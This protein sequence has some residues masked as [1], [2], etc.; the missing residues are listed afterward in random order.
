M[1]KYLLLATTFSTL[2]S[3]AQI[4]IDDTDFAVLEDSVLLST[5]QSFTADVASTGAGHSWDFSNLTP[6]S[7]Y[8][9]SYENIQAGGQIANIVFGQFAAAKY[10]AS[11]FVRDNNLVFELA[12]NVFPVG[13]ERFNRVVK[14]TDDSLTWIGVMLQTD[15][16]TFPVKSDTIET[17]YVY[18]M[19]YGQTHSSRGYT[20][21]NMSPMAEAEWV[22]HRTI[23]SEVDG[24]GVLSTPYNDYT[25][26]RV[27]HD[28]TQ[29]DS[30]LADLQGTG[31]PTW[32]A[33]PTMNMHEYEWW[34]KNEKHPV[35]KIITQEVFGFEVVQSIEYKDI[36]HPEVASIFENS[37]D[38]SIAP[39]PGNEQTTIKSE[40]AIDNILLYSADGKVIQNNTGINALEF[41]ID[42]SEVP[43][44][45][46][47]VEVQS[48]GQSQKS[49]L[50][51]N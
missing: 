22:E 24:W 17:R 4:T 11:Y 44:G 14:L 25:V 47:L 42:L 50:I 49:R 32:T 21:L 46:Y 45:V 15:Q 18:P 28:I 41:T 13:I 19:D 2:F 33:V 8:I 51:R 37:I 36:Y 6:N 20:Y 10:Q 16:G 31:N 3:Q 38:F 39:N 34:A 27:R 30:I 35:L 9:K 5:A 43:V 7:Q 29:S 12:G 48:A 40:T 26:L 1:K 23:D